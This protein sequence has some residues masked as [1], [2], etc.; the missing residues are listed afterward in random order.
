VSLLH[1]CVVGSYIFISGL[2][3]SAT[4]DHVQSRR[5]I[6]CGSKVSLLPPATRPLF[7]LFNETISS[8]PTFNLLLRM[9]VV[10]LR[11]IVLCTVVA[12]FEQQQKKMKGKKESRKGQEGGRKTES[13]SSY[14]F[15][16]VFS[17]RSTI[18]SLLSCVPCFCRLP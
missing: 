1:I 13:D 3:P 5:N 7:N 12:C 18:F 9:E 6:V 15:S 14:S 11:C 17:A 16:I 4:L 8:K 10:E 2:Q